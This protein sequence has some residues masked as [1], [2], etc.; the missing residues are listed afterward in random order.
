MDG[1]VGDANKGTTQFSDGIYS[2]IVCGAINTSALFDGKNVESTE[3]IFQTKDDNGN[4]S[5]V[6]SV[7]LRPSL[8]AKSK[9]TEMMSSWMK[10]TDPKEIK[11]ALIANGI[12]VGDAFSFAGFIGKACQ[13]NIIMTPSK[14]DS[15]KLYTKVSS[16][17]GA[18][19]GDVFEMIPGEY[20][21]WLIKDVLGYEFSPL[22][23]P[24]KPKDNAEKEAALSES[25]SRKVV[26]EEDDG[27]VPF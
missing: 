22:L 7:K 21:L 1:L 14:K 4:V 19:K 6:R 20:P 26:V 27:T 23:T 3:L 15:T 12:V 8:N 17:L 24:A 5:Y 10:K 25:L 18:K 13:L 9:F 2:A 16:V 11:D